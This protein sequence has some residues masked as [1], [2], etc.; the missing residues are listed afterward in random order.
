MHPDPTCFPIPLSVDDSL[1]R[2]PV[3]SA[4]VVIPRCRSAATGDSLTCRPTLT[5]GLQ[6]IPLSSY[7]TT[8]HTPGLQAIP[9]SAEEVLVATALADSMEFFATIITYRFTPSGQTVLLYNN[10]STLYPPIRVAVAAAPG[11]GGDG[12]LMSPGKL[13]MHG[14]SWEG[15]SACLGGEAG[16]KGKARS[17][18]K[19]LVK[20]VCW[21]WFP[22]LS[23]ITLPTDSPCRRRFF[24]VTTSR[25]RYCRRLHHCGY[26]CYRGRH[27]H[28]GRGPLSAPGTTGAVRPGGE[29]E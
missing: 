24:P 20:L 26:S 5:P 16:F 7:P 8:C 9:L 29:V 10:S 2:I 22:E 3:D 21:N 18:L 23:T 4:S 25:Y 1:Y 13:G 15:R 14:G 6:A 12:S 28:R 19:K 17:P 27:C 11:A